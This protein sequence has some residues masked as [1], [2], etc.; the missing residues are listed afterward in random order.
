MEP[1]TDSILNSLLFD[2]WIK[3]YL[4]VEDLMDL[5]VARLQPYMRFYARYHLGY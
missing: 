5:L 4:F 3:D 1:Y 2:L